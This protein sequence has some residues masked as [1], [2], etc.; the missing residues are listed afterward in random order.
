MV[1]SF[2][3]QQT[4]LLPIGSMYGVFTYIFVIFMIHV[5]KYTSP[6]DPMG[7]S[8]RPVL[9]IDQ[10]RNMLMLSTSL[11][12]HFWANYNISPTWSFLK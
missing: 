11:N 2:I 6:M 4:A 3:V 12:N 5:G 9:Q 7:Y 10:L 8:F 1:G